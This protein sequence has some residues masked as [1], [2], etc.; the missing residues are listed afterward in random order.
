[1]KKKKMNPKIKKKIVKLAILLILV[2]V[3]TVEERLP[4]TIWTLV[5]KLMTYSAILYLIINL[6]KI[7]NSDDSAN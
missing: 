5:I 1:M 2:A 6:L 4:D 3:S 7:S